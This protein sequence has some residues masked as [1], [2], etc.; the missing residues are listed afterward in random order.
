MGMPPFSNRNCKTNYYLPCRSSSKPTAPNPDPKRWVL[1]R[2]AE[3]HNGYVLEVRYLDCTNF[4]GLKIMVYK[5]QF[6]ISNHLDPH[7]TNDVNSPI[8]RFRPNKE[9]WRFACDLAKI[10]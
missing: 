9:G 3:Y 6:T 2:K 10:L 8:A 4:E 1:L 7:F 5:G